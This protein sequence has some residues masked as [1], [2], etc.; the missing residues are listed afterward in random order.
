MGAAAGGGGLRP[1]LL[2]RRARR[3]L[4]LSLLLDMI[5]LTRSALTDSSKRCSSHKAE[6]QDTEPTEED[7]WQPHTPV[8]LQPPITAPPR[9]ALQATIASWSH[10]NHLLN[11]DGCKGVRRRWSNMVQCKWCWQL[12]ST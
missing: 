2:T 3:P 7:R 4:A 5:A 12:M 8:Y 11:I 1:A 9:P 6:V 10:S